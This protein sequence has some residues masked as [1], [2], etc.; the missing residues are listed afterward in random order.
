VSFF[1]FSLS[2]KFPKEINNKVHF[3]IPECVELLDAL[4]MKA[5]NSY[6][7]STRKWPEKDSLFFKFQGPSS[8]SLKETATTVQQIVET[9][10]GSGFALARNEKEARDLWMDRKNL[11]HSKRA[12]MKG[13]RALTT[14]VWYVI[15]F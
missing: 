10:G 7:M 4:S 6:G 13:S 15:F 9:H 8:A 14:D 2:S 5:I 1:S 11:F 12:L 3:L